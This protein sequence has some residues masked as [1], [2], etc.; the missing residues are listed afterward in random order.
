MEPDMAS[1]MLCSLQADGYYVKAI[2]AD[3]DSTTA[4]RLK[5]DF[6]SIEKKQDKNHLKKN[7]SKQLYKLAKTYKELKKPGTIPYVVRCF[8]YA[9]ASNDK[10]KLKPI[11]PHIFGNHSLCID[12]AWCTYHK[13]PSVYR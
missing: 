10:S 4:A 2:H 11:V 7:L 3:N 13:N 6:P 12:A 8:M 1:S 5:C 9:I